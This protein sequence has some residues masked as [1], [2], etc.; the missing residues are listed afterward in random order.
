[1]PRPLRR[2]WATAVAVA[3]ALAVSGC[4]A[5]PEATS[6]PTP[7]ATPVAEGPLTLQTLIDLPAAE[8]SWKTT[9][10]VEALAGETAAGISYESGDIS[11]TG[12]L[13][14]PPGDGPFPS[15]VVVH[16]AVDPDLYQ[17]GGDLIPEQRALVE[18]GY[19]VIAVDMRGYAGSDG[20][21]TD[22]SLAIDPGFGWMTVLDWNMSLDVV[23]ALRLARSGD[24]PSLDPSR[25][26]LLGHSLGGLLALDAAVIAPGESDIVVTLAAAPSDFTSALADIE[27][28]SPGAL[29]GAMPTEIAGVPVDEEYWASIS[30]RSHFD[31]VTEPL[32]MIHGTADDATWSVWSEQTVAAWKQTGNQA[33]VVLLDGA[34]HGL[35]PLRSESVAL[36]IAAFDAVIGGR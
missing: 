14:V 23:N 15:V 29:D 19:A 24:V 2:T 8:P 17:T 9:G 4:A 33:E 12:V 20:P 36:T 7:T 5:T 34:D 32:L 30:P 3:V 22:S 28:Q 25:V 21:D 1:M 31:R 18:N 11:V 27:S 13:R 26:G 6:T 35:A 10:A 16:G